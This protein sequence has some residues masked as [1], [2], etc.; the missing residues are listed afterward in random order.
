MT[1][2]EP[3]STE[4]S[5]TVNARMPRGLLLSGMVMFVTARVGL[6]AA[7]PVGC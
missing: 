5:A 1:S 7:P 3:T 6:M 4:A 2:G